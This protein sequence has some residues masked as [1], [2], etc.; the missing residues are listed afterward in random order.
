MHSAYAES[1]YAAELEVWRGVS[2]GL[3]AVIVNPA[4]IVGPADP[5]RSSTQLFRY[6]AGHHRYYPPGQLNV[7]DVRDV[8]TAMLALAIRPDLHGERYTLNA[9]PVSY[10]DFFRLAAAELGSV[11]PTR[12]IPTWLAEILWRVEKARGWLTGAAP[13]LTKETARLSRRASVFDAGRIRQ[14]LGFN[15]RP[16]EEAI[17][18][19]ARELQP[20]LAPH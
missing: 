3:A 20:V 14:K 17:S 5:G 2:E 16:P 7:V 6:A 1:K 10:A 8:V 15:F 11:P 13:L 18:W 4:V 12:P 19:C 9:G